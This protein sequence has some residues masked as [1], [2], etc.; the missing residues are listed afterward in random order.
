MPRD[1][2]QGKAAR[3]D[4]RCPNPLEESGTAPADEEL[5]TRLATIC[6]PTLSFAQLLLNASPDAIIQYSQVKHPGWNRELQGSGPHL[7][8]SWLPWSGSQKGRYLP[9]HGNLASQDKPHAT[10][11]QRTKIHRYGLSP[12][13]RL[14]T[15]CRIKI[16][17]TPSPQ[18]KTDKVRQ[19]SRQAHK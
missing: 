9:K 1:Q 12:H 13:Q 17:P 5:A 2:R 11:G 15:T 10:C 19:A 14:S 3:C 7:S 6:R 18:T 8:L 4:E 16:F